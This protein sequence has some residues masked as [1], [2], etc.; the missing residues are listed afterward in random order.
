MPPKSRAAAIGLGISRSAPGHVD[1]GSLTLRD[2]SIVSQPTAARAFKPPVSE[3]TKIELDPLGI[4]CH[5]CSDACDPTTSYLCVECGAIVCHQTRPG[6]AGCIG[7]GS[8]PTKWEFLCPLCARKVEGKERSLPYKV[9]GYGMRKRVK[10]AWPACIVHITLES[11]KDHYLKLLVNLDLV[12]QYKQSPEN[13]NDSF[14]VGDWRL[15]F[16]IGS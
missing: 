7:H 13:V 9:I 1:I 5:F 6:G 11:M 10:K 4:F 3:I 16:V 14:F 15:T 8:V 12:T 2:S